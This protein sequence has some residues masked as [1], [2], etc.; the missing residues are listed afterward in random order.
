MVRIE[1]HAVA[2]YD[3]ITSRLCADS[4]K[5]VWA[6]KKDLQVEEVRQWHDEVRKDLPTYAMEEVAKHSN[7]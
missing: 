7:S 6:L 3:V 1:F 2:T 5:R 4:G